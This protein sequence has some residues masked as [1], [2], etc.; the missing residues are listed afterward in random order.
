MD[1]WMDG[2]MDGRDEQD[3]RMNDGRMDGRMDGTGGL[4]KLCTPGYVGIAISAQN[5]GC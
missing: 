5:K 2:W 3:G 4:S 1:G